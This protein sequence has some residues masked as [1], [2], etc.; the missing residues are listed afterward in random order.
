MN[1]IWCGEGQPRSTSTQSWRAPGVGP[2]RRLRVA[3]HSGPPGRFRLPSRSRTLVN[4][5]AGSFL[6]DARRPASRYG[7]ATADVNC[8]RRRGGTRAPA[9]ALLAASGGWGWRRHR[10]L[11]MMT[12]DG[13]DSSGTRV[14]ARCVASA[15]WLTDRRACVP[16]L[17]AAGLQRQIRSARTTIFVF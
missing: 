14:A 11:A 6:R 12:V 17:L 8:R 3:C 2:G 7:V 4:A 9:R 13:E 10:Q 16:S 5:P 15:V 1:P